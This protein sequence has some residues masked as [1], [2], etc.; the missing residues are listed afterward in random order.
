VGFRVLGHTRRSKVF[1]LLAFLAFIELC[2][3][4]SII[5]HEV[6]A[7]T[8][9]TIPL[10]DNM[11]SLVKQTLAPIIISYLLLSTCRSATKA[12]LVEAF[13]VRKLQSMMRLV[14]LILNVEMV[15]AIASAVAGMLVFWA[16]MTG[17]SFW[18]AAAGFFSFEL[19]LHARMVGSVI[20]KAQRRNYG[21]K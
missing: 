18:C 21:Q 10:P 2:V 5:F 11:E 9:A 6:S 17:A 12:A 14:L 16:E 13:G 7:G 15:F 19:W 8:P 3:V 20:S 1:R 4:K